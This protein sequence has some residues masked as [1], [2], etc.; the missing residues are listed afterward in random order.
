[1]RGLVLS[2]SNNSFVVEAAGGAR[3]TCGIKGK[4]LKEDEGRYN[5]LAPGDYVDVEPDSHEGGSKGLILSREERRNEFCRWNEKGKALQVLAA[6]LDLLLCVASPALPPFRPRF[7]DRALAM[8]ELSSIPA[9][10][11]LN[12][13]D[14]GVGPDT[15][16]RLA[17]YERIGYRVLR[18]SAA[19]RSG[20][21]P[22]AALL[23]G[24]L[25]AFVGQSG[26]GKSSLLNLLNSEAGRMVGELSVKYERGAHTTTR[27]ALLPLR[28]GRPLSEGGVIDT[29]GVRRLAVS[30]A[31]P[32]ELASLF[33]ELR[34][35]SGKCSYG[36]S[37]THS[38]EP[39]CR[40]LEAV[41][42]GAVHEDRFESYLRM[43]EEI[44]AR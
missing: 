27:G 7:I 36:L 30:G 8:A 31:G 35:L 39:G 41:Y 17:D 4:K 37:C 29:P 12:K 42:A 13:Q 19:E 18:C 11:L 24:K 28:A 15:E 44:E 33:P 1:M 32:R 16:E 6:N 38:H 23:G 43:R 3:L 14:L 34:E 10:I 20:I 40:L 2:G 5:P 26:V 9:A 25:T 22:L 21:E